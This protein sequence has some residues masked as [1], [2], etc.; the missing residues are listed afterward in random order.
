MYWRATGVSA[1]D[2]ERRFTAIARPYR[3]LGNW[4]L[5]EVGGSGEPIAPFLAWWMLLYALSMLTR[6]EPGTWTAALDVDRT[7]VAAALEVTV[8]EALTAIPDIIFEVL[9]H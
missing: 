2:R 7:E 6:Y 8:D 4:L 1:Q 5:P 3:D 9:A